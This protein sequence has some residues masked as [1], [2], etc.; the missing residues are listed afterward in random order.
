MMRGR[1]KEIERKRGKGR[2]D[3]KRETDWES[4]RKK[5][6]DPKYITIFMIIPYS[7]SYSTATFPIEAP[8][9]EICS[10]A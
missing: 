6:S 5:K 10:P 1:K 4:G 8:R 2:E 3:I 7:K 9:K